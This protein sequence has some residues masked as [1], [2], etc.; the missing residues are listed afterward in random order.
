M[1]E[2]QPKLQIE[3]IVKDVLATIEKER[4]REIVA[5]R[6]GLFDRKETLEQI[7]ELLG[8]TRERVRQLKRPLSPALRPKQS[9]GTFLIFLK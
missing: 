5:R 7:G 6:Y 2:K 3:Q 1:A 8:I 4:E 9:R